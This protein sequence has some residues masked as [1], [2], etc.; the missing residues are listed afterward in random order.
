MSGIAHAAEMGAP[1]HLAREK[2]TPGAAMGTFS[3]SRLSPGNRRMVRIGDPRMG[4]LLP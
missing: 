1:W 2:L 3:N 4:P